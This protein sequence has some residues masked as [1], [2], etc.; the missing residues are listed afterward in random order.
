MSYPYHSCVS[1]V[2]IDIEWVLSSLICLTNTCTSVDTVNKITSSSYTFYF[3][4]FG[5]PFHF[6][7]VVAKL[8]FLI[9]QAPTTDK[10]FSE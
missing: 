6:R 8:Y 3:Q 10:I 7:N 5:K 2:S 9:E 4:A 1:V